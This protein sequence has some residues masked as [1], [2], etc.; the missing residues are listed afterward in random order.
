MRYFK[1]KEIDKFLR[2]SECMRP[3]ETRAISLRKL[4]EYVMKSTMVIHEDEL[5]AM[6][7]CS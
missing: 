2:R 5:M 1:R 7:H 6:P 3:D 4:R